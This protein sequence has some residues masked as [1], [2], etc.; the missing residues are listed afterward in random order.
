M[1]IGRKRD[2]PRYIKVEENNGSLTKEKESNAL[3][4]GE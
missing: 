2:A 3:K 1:K 4:I